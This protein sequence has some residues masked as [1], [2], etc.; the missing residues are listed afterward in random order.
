[1]F[2]R[3]SSFI[4]PIV[5][6][7]YGCPKCSASSKRITLLLNSEN[8]SKTCVLPIAHSPKVS[9]AFFP[10]CKAKLN[11]DMLFLQVCHFIGTPEFQ[12]K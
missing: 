2:S 4:Q 3:T 5:L 12:I 8:H 6:L 10:H 1:M 9:V 7:I 11:A